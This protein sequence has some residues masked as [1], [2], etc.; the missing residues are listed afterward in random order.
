[1]IVISNDVDMW[2]PLSLFVTMAADLALYG[3]VGQTRQK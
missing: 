3:D 1:M 2:L